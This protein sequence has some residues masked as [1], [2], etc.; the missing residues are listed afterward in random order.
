MIELFQE[1]TLP[2]SDITEGMSGA[3]DGKSEYKYYLTLVS[4]GLRIKTGDTVYLF[5]KDDD[6]HPN[7]KSLKRKPK[8]ESLSEESK[9]DYII[10]RVQHLMI[11]KEGR[12]LVYG[13]HYLRPSETY[14]EP[15]RKFYVNEVLRSP[16]NEWVPIEEVKGLCCVLD[17]NTYCKG[18]PK[19]F[20]EEDV[21]ICEMRTDRN[22]KSFNKIS[23][24]NQFFINTKSYAFDMFAKKLS[25]KRTYSVIILFI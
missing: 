1:I 23:K 21:Y 4:N 15:S 20:K 19:G 25:I 14:H 16:L 10:F 8:S 11:N 12:K 9:S 2:E 7:H 3:N 17:P 13:H 6:K 18:R 5:R 22:A 24:Q